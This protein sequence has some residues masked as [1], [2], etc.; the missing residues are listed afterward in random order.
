M[1]KK[2]LGFLPLALGF[3]VLAQPAPADTIDQSWIGGGSAFVCVSSSPCSHIA[4]TFTAGI[5][6]TLTGVYIQSASGGGTPYVLS[7]T[8]VSN[9]MPTSTV[10]ASTAIL[11]NHSFGITTELIPLS[12]VSIVQGQ[13]YAIVISVPSGG[14]L[15][16]VGA[17]GYAGG[18]AWH[19]FDGG[20]TWFFSAFGSGY[21]FGFQTQVNPVPEPG[22]LLLLGTGLAGLALRRKFLT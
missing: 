22:T 15:E 7:I 3:L 17:H 21:D 14:R 6:A 4:Q 18:T 20:S 1:R 9:G 10:L 13:Q 19:S 12:L 16:W 11:G 2:L 8:T 5:T